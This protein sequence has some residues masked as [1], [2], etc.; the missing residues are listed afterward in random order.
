MRQSEKA[1]IDLLAREIWRYNECP[2]DFD[3][4]PEGMAA[5]QKQ[6][7][8]DHAAGLVGIVLKSP[9]FRAVL[10]AAP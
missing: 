8:L 3:A 10:S 2:W 5:L 9:L 1:M 6:I 7:A 4:P